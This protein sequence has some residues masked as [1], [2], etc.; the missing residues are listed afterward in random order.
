MA[1]E[2]IRFGVKLARRIDGILGEIAEKVEGRS[3]SNFHS[4]VCRRLAAMWQDPQKQKQLIEIGL[5]R[6]GVE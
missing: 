1:Q 4:S 3:K 6:R 2:E 5:I